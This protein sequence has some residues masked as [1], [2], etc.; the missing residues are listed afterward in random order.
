M[1]R[2]DGT[3]LHPGFTPPYIL[4]RLREHGSPR[5]RRC[6]EATLTRDRGFRAARG[7]QRAARKPEASAPGRPARYI[8]SAEHRETLPGRLVREEDQPGGDDPAVEEAYRWLGATYRFFWEVFERHSIDANGMPLIGTVH[9]GQDY[10]NAF[11]N[12]AQMVFGG[13]SK[14]KYFHDVHTLDVERLLWSQF[15]VTGTAPHGRVSHTATRVGE[16]V[17]IFGGSAG[18][19]CVPPSPPPR[20]TEAAAAAVSARLVTHPST[21]SCSSS[22]APRSEPASASSPTSGANHGT[23]VLRLRPRSMSHAS[24]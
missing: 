7:P 19:G 14:G 20:R 12:G 5:Q 1:T 18:G 13:F 16:E 6:A 8:H 17:L 23:P 24:M 11:W 4:E 22:S 21:T 10:A 9:F 3:I 15:I 2:S